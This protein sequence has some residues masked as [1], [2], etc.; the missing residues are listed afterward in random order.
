M[1]SRTDIEKQTR[2]IDKTKSQI[3]RKE[4]VKKNQFNGKA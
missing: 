1:G 2:K 4:R 3:D